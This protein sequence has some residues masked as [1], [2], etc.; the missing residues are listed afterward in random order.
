P[1][2]ASTD[3]LP[4]ITERSEVNGSTRRPEAAETTRRRE[5]ATAAG[6]AGR[7][8]TTQEPQLFSLPTSPC[9]CGSVLD[10]LLRHESY[11]RG[12]S[13]HAVNLDPGAKIAGAS[14]GRPEALATPRSSLS[15]GS[16][17]ARR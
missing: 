11:R 7:M 10:R 12:D 5:R 2:S 14:H 17:T 8:L 1:P 15:C 4:Q 6:N 9:L 13:G 3:A 16:G